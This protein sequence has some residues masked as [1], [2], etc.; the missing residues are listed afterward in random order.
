MHRELAGLV[1]PP[2]P[3]PPTAAAPV[4][5]RAPF[6]KDRP[7]TVMRIRGIKAEGLPDAD[8]TV[9][10]GGSDPF[11]KFTLETNLNT[12][13][14]NTGARFFAKTSTIF[15]AARTVVFP[16]VVE[17][18][19]PEHAGRDLM[20]GVCE[21]RLRAA[22]WDDDTMDDD[23]GD[24]L[25]GEMVTEVRTPYS[26]VELKGSVDR[27]VTGGVAG[28]YPFLFSFKYACA[29]EA[30]KKRQERERQMQRDK[31]KL[32]RELMAGLGVA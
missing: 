16:D 13:N 32:D 12:G 6:D 27:K 7:P 15:N 29:S 2:P 3:P 4:Q 24:D 14:I 23:D 20:S 10:G 5:R 1:Y 11:V 8:K 26:G 25:M 9:G 18:H 31:E 17:I 22:V 30:E 19:F 21:A 28:F